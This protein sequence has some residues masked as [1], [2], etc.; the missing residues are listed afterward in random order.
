V[1][2]LAPLGFDTADL[3]IVSPP[4]KTQFGV[5]GLAWKTLTD[6]LPL[7]PGDQLFEGGRFCWH[8]LLALVR[9]TGQPMSSVLWR[10]RAKINRK[11][12]LFLSPITAG[13]V[14]AHDFT[15]SAGIKRE[16]RHRIL[17]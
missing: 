12:Q 10:G 11:H 9:H 16:L 17:Q 7:H 1:P 13:L 4:G 5:A 8:H 15:G 3:R 6:Q 2:L 14:V